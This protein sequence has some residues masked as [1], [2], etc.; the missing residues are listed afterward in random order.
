VHREEISV[1][2]DIPTLLFIAFAPGL[3][4]LWYLYHRDRYHHEPLR[5]L[6]W[7]F[8]VGMLVTIPV[9][10]IENQLGSLITEFQLSVIAAP[11]IEEL[12]KFSVVALTVYSEDV[13]D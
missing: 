8:L 11:V 4:Y 5:W 6:F 3:F 12:A 10:F 9:A 1:A 2:L 7:V 13:F